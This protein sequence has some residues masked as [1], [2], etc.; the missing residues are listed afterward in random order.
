[1]DRDNPLLT[2]NEDLG[3]IVFDKTEL[4]AIL[5]N[6][7]IFK[8]ALQF[9]SLH[10]MAIPGFDDTYSLLADYV[11]D[12]LAQDYFQDLCG[13]EGFPIPKNATLTDDPTENL[14]LYF[15]FVER[16]KN[17]FTVLSAVDQPSDF[18][19]NTQVAGRPLYRCQKEEQKDVLG[20]ETGTI[21]HVYIDLGV[22]ELTC[23]IKNENDPQFFTKWNI[24]PMG[25]PLFWEMIDPTNSMSLLP[26]LFL[27]DIEKNSD[28]PAV[29]DVNTAASSSAPILFSEFE[30]ITISSGDLEKIDRFIDG[31]NYVRDYSYT[32]NE[33]AKILMGYLTDDT[34][35]EVGLE[36]DTITITNAEGTVTWA[37]RQLLL[38]HGYTLEKYEDISGRV[39]YYIQKTDTVAWLINKATGAERL[40]ALSKFPLRFSEGDFKGFFKKMDDKDLP[41]RLTFLLPYYGGYARMN[42]ATELRNTPWLSGLVGNFNE[43]QIKNDLCLFMDDWNLYQA[44]F[45]EPC[46]A[47][48]TGGMEAMDQASA[49]LA[50]L[51]KTSTPRIA[52]AALLHMAMG[53]G[54]AAD[55]LR[56]VLPSVLSQI[57]YFIPKEAREKKKGEVTV[58][59]QNEGLGNAWYTWHPQQ[60]YEMASRL[61]L[62]TPEQLKGH[63]ALLDFDYFATGLKA[64]DNNFTL[65]RHPLTIDLPKITPSAPKEDILNFDLLSHFIKRDSTREK[66]G[67]LRAEKSELMLIDVLTLDWD[68]VQRE[69]IR[70]ALER[71]ARDDEDGFVHI[72]AAVVL[73]SRPDALDRLTGRDDK[74][75]KYELL[76]PKALAKV[77][78]KYPKVASKALEWLFM[79]DE[80]RAI[81]TLEY[82]LGFV[83]YHPEGFWDNAIKLLV[84]SLHPKACAVLTMARSLSDLKLAA[85]TLKLIDDKLK[86]PFDADYFKALCF[87]LEQDYKK[88]Q[89]QK[90]SDVYKTVLFYALCRKLE[91]M[92]IIYGG[93]LTWHEEMESGFQALFGTELTISL[94]CLYFECESADSFES[95][96]NTLTFIQKTLDEYKA[97]YGD[98]EMGYED[99]LSVISMYLSHYP[100]LRHEQELWT[101]VFEALDKALE[102]E[103]PNLYSAGRH[104]ELDEIAK[105]FE[106]FIK[107]VP[108]PD[109]ITVPP[110]YQM[111]LFYLG[112]SNY[113]DA[114]FTAGAAEKGIT[115]LT[116]KEPFDYWLYFFDS[117]SFNPQEGLL[118]MYEHLWQKHGPFFLKTEVPT[119]IAIEGW[120][121]QDCLP[122]YQLFMASRGQW[123]EVHSI[124]YD[125]IDWKNPFHARVMSAY[126]KNLDT[127]VLTPD[128]ADPLDSTKYNEKLYPLDDVLVFLERL[129]SLAALKMPQGPYERDIYNLESD[130]LEALLE[131]LKNNM[132]LVLQDIADALYLGANGYAIE[133]ETPEMLRKIKETIPGDSV[134]GYL[135]SLVQAILGD[136]NAINTLWQFHDGE[137]TLASDIRF[138]GD[139]VGNLLFYGDE[140]L[141]HH[142]PARFFG[143]H[144]PQANANR[145]VVATVEMG[146]P[147]TAIKAMAPHIQLSRHAQQA[148]TASHSTFTA[149]VVLGGTSINGDYHGTVRSYVV[150]EKGHIFEG[151]DAILG[152]VLADVRRGK[153]TDVVSISLASYFIPT[154]LNTQDLLNSS[155]VHSIKAKLAALSLHRI[156]VVIA[157]G[158][159]GSVEIMESNAVQLNDLAKISP[160]FIVVGSNSGLHKKEGATYSF[161]SGKLPDEEPRRVS[162]FSSTGNPSA[163]VDVVSVGEGIDVFTGA[164]FEKVDGTSFSTPNVAAVLATMKHLAPMATVEMLQA[165]LKMTA[166]DLKQDTP[167]SEGA[168]EVNTRDA[169]YVASIINPF[170]TH[171]KRLQIAEE[172]GYKQDKAE[173]LIWLAN[174]IRQQVW[175]GNAHRQSYGE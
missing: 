79:N 75:L 143:I 173:D 108:V 62:I 33:I 164:L 44:L 23:S 110:T 16:V 166:T 22:V 24:K 158:N 90:G 146:K 1:M 134:L 111:M 167:L 28:W 133:S 102:A 94:K 42:W 15:Q 68:N 141:K 93:P 82:A 154:S 78:L 45:T 2:D 142:N 52:L 71:Y 88:Y 83:P 150:S 130:E 157:A 100:E 47:F 89:D 66:L 65:T 54:K 153:K 37:L 63:I 155:I 53:Q 96:M 103:K 112:Q 115:P 123:G 49:I 136:E 76:P 39:T 129:A 67:L 19:R 135:F 85:K 8:H 70:R 73:R 125:L 126:K 20:N 5:N 97:G 163:R 48:R 86:C 152:Q 95:L 174:R 116:V 149:Q 40:V 84:A 3:G 128:Y 25:D 12:H 140:F 138:L 64:I 11:R 72:A 41:G 81:D 17:E 98:L 121:K 120:K 56:Q 14:K 21:Y 127:F 101:F 104:V 26:T 35:V 9:G 69:D 34:S 119:S 51:Q 168:G 61:E 29:F 38:K 161:I 59:T 139:Q 27:A 132:D 13:L 87:D 31:I 160:H 92:M 159:E 77:V 162:R 137:K 7:P 144:T 99:V 107:E 171:K 165:I 117:S 60:F 36:A 131:A 122:A 43:E 74:N 80:K 30:N 57:D 32:E 55:E 6:N 172:F 113:A 105:K 18:L 46:I 151:V 124:P 175:F 118:A 147:D 10:T 145:N 170:M 148:A 109:K 169:L 106:A 50:A 4:A 58:E 114:I 91:G 156:P